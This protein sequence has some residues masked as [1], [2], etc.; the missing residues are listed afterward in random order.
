MFGR[1]FE[2]REE[3]LEKLLENKNVVHLISGGIFSTLAIVVEKMF[4]VNK[5]QP[6]FVNRGHENWFR[7]RMAV[8]DVIEL[9]SE[10]FENIND[11][12]ELV[13][14][15]PP[16]SLD[17]IFPK[18]KRENK[19]FGKL[20]E[21]INNAVRVALCLSDYGENYEVITTGSL[22]TKSC[23]QFYKAKNLEVKSILKDKSISIVA[24]FCYLKLDKKK[25][26]KYA[27]HRFPTE[28]TIEVLKKAWSCSKYSLEPC[29]RCESCKEKEKMLKIALKEYSRI[30]T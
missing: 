28:E 30:I 22:Y 16:I 5:I 27:I 3:E 11:P 26:I 9:L 7:E 12:V 25:A 24:P 18:A 15:I 10:L 20:S 4:E 19:D 1:R 21:M 6:V 29:G 2:K 23:S 17:K 8:W 13:T 14:Y